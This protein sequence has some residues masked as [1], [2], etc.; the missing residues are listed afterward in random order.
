MFLKYQKYLYTRID[1]I[2]FK[3][4]FNSEANSFQR[5]V[6]GGDLCRANF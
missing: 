2:D 3:N 6:S 4:Q 1:L 5:I